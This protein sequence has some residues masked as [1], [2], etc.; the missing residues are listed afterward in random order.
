MRAMALIVISMCT[1][2]APAVAAAQ[3]AAELRKQI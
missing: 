3:D 1:A 2:L